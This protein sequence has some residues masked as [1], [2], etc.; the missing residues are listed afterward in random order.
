MIFDGVKSDI[1]EM[2]VKKQDEDLEPLHK[3]VLM[4]KI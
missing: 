4:E 2:V 1:T 3:P